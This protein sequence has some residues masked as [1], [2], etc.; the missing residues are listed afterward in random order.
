M[1][2]CASMAQSMFGGTAQTSLTT[3]GQSSC[4]GVYKPVYVRYTAAA[5]NCC[6]LSLSSQF[7]FAKAGIESWSMTPT[8]YGLWQK[9]AV[10]S[11]LACTCMVVTKHAWLC[12]DQLLTLLSIVC[13][14]VLTPAGCSWLVCVSHWNHHLPVLLDQAV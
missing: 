12:K 7:V 13:A 4:I 2:A 6:T 1:N 5:F 14:A 3:S 11:V 10:V 8:L 9:L